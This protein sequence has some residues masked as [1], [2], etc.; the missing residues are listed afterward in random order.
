M[1]YPPYNIKYV[2]ILPWTVSISNVISEFTVMDK[3]IAHSMENVNYKQ[4]EAE[5]LV[6]I[7]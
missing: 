4:K 1:T 6:N 2:L 3:K 7:T 5:P